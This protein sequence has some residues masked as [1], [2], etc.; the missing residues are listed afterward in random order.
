MHVTFGNLVSTLPMLDFDQLL[1]CR[2][3]AQTKTLGVMKE[4]GFQKLFF[5]RK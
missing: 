4:N 3:N 1:L 2:G 5:R